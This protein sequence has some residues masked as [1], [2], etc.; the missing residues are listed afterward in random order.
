M[1]HVFH[2]VG[3]ITRQTVSRTLQSNAIHLQPYSIPHSSIPSPIT[4]TAAS[5]CNPLISNSQRTQIRTVPRANWFTPDFKHQVHITQ[6]YA[7][8]TD[9]FVSPQNTFPRPGANVYDHNK[10]YMDC[11]NVPLTFIEEVFEPTYHK[12][13]PTKY[14]PLKWVDARTKFKK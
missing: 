10:V 8:R 12:F 11:N 4:S 7:T 1:S 6:P 2:R 3:F 14:K 9:M 5:S 13:D